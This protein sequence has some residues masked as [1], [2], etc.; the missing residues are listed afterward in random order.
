MSRLNRWERVFL[1]VR[2]CVRFSYV[3]EACLFYIRSER[4]CLS[5]LITHIYLRSN[6]QVESYN[7]TRKGHIHSGVRW[8]CCSVDRDSEPS[9]G[10]SLHSLVT[11]CTRRIPRETPGLCGAA[12]I[13]EP[14]PKR[15]E[16]QQEGSARLRLCGCVLCRCYSRVSSAWTIPLPY[17][18]WLQSWA[19]ILYSLFNKKNITLHYGDAQDRK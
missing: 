4:S 6:S 7:S 12:L 11:D 13:A 15:T 17:M 8:L 10:Q 16:K 14:R 9:R 3:L 2:Y 18:S 1:L 5:F 19:T